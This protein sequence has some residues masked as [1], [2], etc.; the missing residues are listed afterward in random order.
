MTVTE[1]DASDVAPEQVAIRELVHRSSDVI[2]H[3]WPMRSFVHHN[4][5]RGLEVLPFEDAIRRGKTFVGGSGYLPNEV[6][7]KHFRSGKILK[8]D[9]DD[10]VSARETGTTDTQVAIG[11]KQVRQFDVFLAHLLTGI[12]A[13]AR[14]H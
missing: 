14:D 8:Q 9:L 11:T 10:A 5:L 3:Y 1:S 2:A 7:R 4:P 6:Y 13:P 12:T